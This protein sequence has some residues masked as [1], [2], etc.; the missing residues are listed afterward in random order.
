MKLLLAA[1]VVLG[2]A[3]VALADGMP[4]E[5]GRFVGAVTVLGLTVDQRQAFETGR[6]LRLSASQRQRI[7]ADSGGPSPSELLVYFTSRG[8]NDCTCGIYNVALRFDEEHVEVPH[9][10]LVDDAEAARRRAEWPGER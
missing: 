9:E 1:L 6:S 10:Y 2:L 7:E 5:D 4:I 3:V 8:E